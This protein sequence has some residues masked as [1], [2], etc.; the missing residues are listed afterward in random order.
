MHQAKHNN[1][2]FRGA[3]LVGKYPLIVSALQTE[4]EAESGAIT[5]ELAPQVRERLLSETLKRQMA[6]LVCMI[7]TSI[8]MIDF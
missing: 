2:A 4:R 5:L 8:D 6:I 3:G 7:L 1:G